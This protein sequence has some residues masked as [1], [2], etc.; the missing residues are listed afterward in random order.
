LLPKAL[1]AKLRACTALT[2]V[3][4]ENNKLIQTYLHQSP[5]QLQ[6]CER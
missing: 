3:Q 6:V 5:A 2:K 4:K 1:V